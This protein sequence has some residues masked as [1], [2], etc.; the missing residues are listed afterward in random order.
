MRKK[1]CL[2]CIDNQKYI[3]IVVK[4]IKKATKTQAKAENTVEKCEKKVSK[5]FK[6]Y[7]FSLKTLYMIL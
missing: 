7:V 4:T 6:T 2:L 5:P 3:T 1:R